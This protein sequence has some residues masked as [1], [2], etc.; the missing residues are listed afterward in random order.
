MDD[1]VTLGKVQAMVVSILD[2]YSY[3]ACFPGVSNSAS[4]Y[5]IN[6]GKWRC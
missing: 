6:Q 5:P 2:M 1:A 4:G 3:K